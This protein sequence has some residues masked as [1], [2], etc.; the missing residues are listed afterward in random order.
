MHEHVWTYSRDLIGD[1]RLLANI[2]D[3]GFDNFT[4]CCPLIKTGVSGRRQ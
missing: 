4:D 2:A 3:Y 1:L